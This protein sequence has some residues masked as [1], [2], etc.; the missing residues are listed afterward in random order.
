MMIRPWHKDG[1][2]GTAAADAGSRMLSVVVVV[3]VPAG[4]EEVTVVVVVG[5]VWLVA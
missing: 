4:P 5:M 3:V 2:T 1:S